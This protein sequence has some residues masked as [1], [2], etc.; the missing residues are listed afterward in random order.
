MKE[1]CTKAWKLKARFTMQIHGERIFPFKFENEEDM[2]NVVEMG[3]FH[4]ASQLCI[5]R[6]WKLFLE[7]EVREMKTIPIWVILKQ[8]PLELWDNE[9]FS[10]V[11]SAIGVPLFT[12]KLTEERRRT[13]YVR[14]CVEVDV[15]Y[16][17]P[18][19]INVV[20]DRSREIKIACEYNWRPPQCSHCKVFRH[21]EVKCFHKPA[22]QGKKVTTCVEKDQNEVEKGQNQTEME[23]MEKTVGGIMGDREENIRKD[24]LNGAR[25]GRG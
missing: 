11:C 25:C 3:S 18:K 19:E 2:S 16:K 23:T 4:V 7:D 13:S 1:V 12:N 22:K 24:N 10:M 9:G 15:N 6:P 14:V 21:N 8:F 17:Y 20:L 5:I